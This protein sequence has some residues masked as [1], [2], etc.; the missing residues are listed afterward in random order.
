[1][2]FCFKCIA[3]SD[4]RGRTLYASSECQ[5]CGKKLN[6]EEMGRWIRFGDSK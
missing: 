3:K 6:K 5:D 2:T 1:M 4:K